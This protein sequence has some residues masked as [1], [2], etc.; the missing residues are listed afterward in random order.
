MAD[1]TRIISSFES[2][3]LQQLKSLM[4]GSGGGGSGGAEKK[5]KEKEST[6]T[7]SL[8]EGLKR[9][10]T[11][12]G[13]LA[14]G[15]AGTAAGLA[16]RGFAGT[17]D[18]ARLNFA[19]DR[20]AAQMAAV[21][22]PVIQGMTYAASRM[23][24]VMRSL[25]GDQQNRLLKTGLGT[26]AGYALGGAPG[27]LAGGLV[28]AGL[29]GGSPML[30]AAGGALLGYRIGGPIGAAVG[31]TAAALA[32][33]PS[34]QTDEKP[35]EYYKR[36]R[37]QG[38][39]R[40]GSAFSV[41]T[42]AVNRLFGEDEVAPPPPGAPPTPRR[43]APIKFQVAEEEAGGAAR[44]IQEAVMLTTSGQDADGGPY[45][46]AIDTIIELLAKIAGVELV[47]ATSGAARAR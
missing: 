5:E 41:A 6:T 34:I 30:A 37:D 28:G 40:L 8:V 32:A 17:A 3:A 39:S 45:K 36:M 14:A 1:P 42:A 9:V 21:F 15:L 38:G 20:L 35:F 47:P 31:G 44:R 11:G 27:A 19:M 18:S 26:M 2:A 12:L 7:R 24:V 16:T 10:E 22:Q 23:T 4:T 43:E 25:N 33:T 13:R 46:E 29:G